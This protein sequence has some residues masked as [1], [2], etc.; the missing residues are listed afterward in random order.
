MFY[1][2]DRRL[3]TADRSYLAVIGLPSVILSIPMQFSSSLGIF[4]RLLEDP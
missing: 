1:L 2:I 3:K 4:L